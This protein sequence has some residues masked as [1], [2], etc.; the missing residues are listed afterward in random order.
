MKQSG[1]RIHRDLDLRLSNAKCRFP[2]MDRVD[3]KDERE[4]FV[5]S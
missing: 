1:I 5:I 2:G 4:A 3:K